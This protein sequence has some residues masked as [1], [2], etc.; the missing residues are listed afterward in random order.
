MPPCKNDKT[1]SYIGNE[2]SPK[3]LGYCAHAEKLFSVM[4]GL[5]DRYWYV[6]SRKWKLLKIP[7]KWFTQFKKLNIKVNL[8][9]SNLWIKNYNKDLKQTI[10]KKIKKNIDNTIIVNHTESWHVYNNKEFIKA[11]QSLTK[12]K[13]QFTEQGMQQNNKASMELD[14]DSIIK[15]IKKY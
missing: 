15:I 11:I 4:I 9:T 1:K 2:P 3:G 8:D 5:D 10:I 6:S 7:S 12:L 13:F 14:N